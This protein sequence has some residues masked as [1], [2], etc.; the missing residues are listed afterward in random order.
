[1]LMIAEQDHG[2]SKNENEFHRYCSGLSLPY[3]DVCIN[4]HRTITLD[5]KSIFDTFI[6]NKETFKEVD[7]VKKSIKKLITK[8]AQPDIMAMSI[9]KHSGQPVNR[10]ESKEIFFEQFLL[11]F[12]LNHVHDCK[13]P[14]EKLGMLYVYT[15]I[16]EMYYD[17]K[18]P[19]FKMNI[20]NG[21]YR[22]LEKGLLEKLSF[23]ELCIA[24]RI[25]SLSDG[26]MIDFLTKCYL[27]RFEYVIRSFSGGL[28]K[29]RGKPYKNTGYSLEEGDAEYFTKQFTEKYFSYEEKGVYFFER[30]II[31]AIISRFGNDKLQ[32]IIKEGNI[33][34]LSPSLKNDLCL[35][36]ALIKATDE[37]QWGEAIRLINSLEVI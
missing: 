37:G 2:F 22:K 20:V 18:I 17:V 16:L 15:D 31:E 14:H 35:H 5:P 26:D 12:L 21:V 25:V 34:K 19:F 32:T 8:N 9:R 7:R 23:S 4:F 3:C 10:S 36:Y 27:N 30:K 6:A 28:F 11:L 29:Y 24:Y 1:M 33:F 13:E